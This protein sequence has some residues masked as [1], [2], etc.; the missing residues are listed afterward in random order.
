MTPF[1]RGMEAMNGLNVRRLLEDSSLPIEI[2]TALAD[3]YE[4]TQ[5]PEA[6]APTEDVDVL[7]QMDWNRLMSGDRRPLRAERQ[8]HFDRYYA[9]M[10]ALELLR[11]VEE[12]VP[13][14]KFD[15]DLDARVANFLSSLQPQRAHSQEDK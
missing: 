6:N 1:E 3:L 11:E 7:A 13:L 12:A 4:R 8:S 9:G 14:A 2:A 5:R 15:M 10:A